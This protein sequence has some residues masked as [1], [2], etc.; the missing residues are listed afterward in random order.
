MNT[1]RIATLLRS[2]AD[3]FESAALPKTS[4]QFFQHGRAR[5]GNADQ[6]ATGGAALAGTSTAPDRSTFQQQR[7]RKGRAV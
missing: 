3:E 2:L 1:M 4:A 6:A 5:G 7:R